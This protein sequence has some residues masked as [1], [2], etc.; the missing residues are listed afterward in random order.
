[1]FVLGVPCLLC[2]MYLPLIQLKLPLVTEMSS[3]RAQ[4]HRVFGQ[5]YLLGEISPGLLPTCSHLHWLLPGHGLGPF[6]SSSTGLPSP[7][8]FPGAKAP[9]W[10]A[11]HPSWFACHPGGA[12]CGFLRKRTWEVF[13]NTFC[14]HTHYT[15]WL[16]IEFQV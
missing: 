11:C 13:K 12:L 2:L 3:Q 5:V 7:L 16:R 6:S 9:S 10:F 15:V 1:M 4:A 14:L 8:L